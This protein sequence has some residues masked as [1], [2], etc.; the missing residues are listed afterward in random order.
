VKKIHLS[1]AQGPAACKPISNT[2]AAMKAAAIMTHLTTAAIITYILT[3]YL[4]F[5]LKADV[6]LFDVISS[7]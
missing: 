2:R 4:A 5:Y 1:H 3:F 7:I 6:V